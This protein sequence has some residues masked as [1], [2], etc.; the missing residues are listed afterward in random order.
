MRNRVKFT[1]IFAVISFKEFVLS[2]PYFHQSN[3]AILEDRFRTAIAVF[4]R[5][6]SVL[7]CTQLYCIPVIYNTTYKTFYNRIY[8]NED[9]IDFIMRLPDIRPFFLHIVSLEIYIV[10]GL[11]GFSNSYIRS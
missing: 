6:S 7:S 11:C 1:C 5:C 3:V 4:M 10:C 9:C 8:N 2:E